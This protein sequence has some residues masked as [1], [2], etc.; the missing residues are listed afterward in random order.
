MDLAMMLSGFS[1]L[2]AAFVVSAIW[3]TRPASISHDASA[4]PRDG[5]TRRKRPTAR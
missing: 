3:A 5:G 1:G 4:I 2:V